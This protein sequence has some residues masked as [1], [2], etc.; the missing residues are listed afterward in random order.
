MSN[1]SEYVA[2]FQGDQVHPMSLVLSEDLVNQLGEVLI[3]A[4][5]KVEASLSLVED[6]AQIVAHYIVV[7]GFAMPIQASSYVMPVQERVMR[8]QAEKSAEI[9]MYS[10]P[11]IEGVGLMLDEPELGEGLGLVLP[12][13]FGGIFGWSDVEKGIVVPQQDLPLMI[14]VP[15]EI[16]EKL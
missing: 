6:G 13:L 12:L 7:D 8:S 3:P 1:P 10:R 15:I 5:A 9:M 14:E 4:G 2:R 16:S 11:I